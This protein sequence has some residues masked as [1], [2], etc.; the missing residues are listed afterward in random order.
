MCQKK[1]EERQQKCE[2]RAAAK[3]KQ[4]RAAKGKEKA[5][6]SETSPVSPSPHQMM[7]SFSNPISTALQ[8]LHQQSIPQISGIID[9]HPLEESFSITASSSVS[10]SFDESLNSMHS[11]DD[12]NLADTA[13]LPPIHMAPTVEPSHLQ[14]DVESE[15]DPAD[16]TEQQVYTIPEPKPMKTGTTTFTS[17]DIPPSK[18]A[19]R[20]QDFHAWMT[21]KHLTE[22]SCYIILVEFVAQFTGTLKHWWLTLGESDKIVF[23]TRQTFPEVINLL[24][25]TFLGNVQEAREEKRQTFFKMK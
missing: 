14:L 12:T 13:S 11:G 6:S 20:F 2:A 4:A 17:D 24:H 23:L 21:T 9:S 5:E 25:N 16:T 1:A 15:F 22:E 7:V 8:D 3:A 18:W 10:E 19:D